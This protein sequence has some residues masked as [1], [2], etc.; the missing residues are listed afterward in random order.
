MAKVAFTRV[1]IARQGWDA[2]HN[3]RLAEMSRLSPSSSLRTSKAPW[4]EPLAEV[5]VV[6]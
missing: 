2:K 4:R 5:P 6:P 1:E 3:G